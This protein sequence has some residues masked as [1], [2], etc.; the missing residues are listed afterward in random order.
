MTTLI[1]CFAQ[2][3]GKRW[4]AICLDFD[5]S[6][7]GDSF[8]AVYRSLDAAVEEY[9]KYVAALEDPAER[10]AFLSRRAPW[11]VRLKFT[12]AMA[13]ASLLLPSRDPRRPDGHPGLGT[14]F[15]LP[16]AA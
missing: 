4:E 14:G 13:L 8:E 3:R 10:E 1:R 2:R 16:A 12:L 6:V 15:T 11:P 5:L 7:Q 9:L